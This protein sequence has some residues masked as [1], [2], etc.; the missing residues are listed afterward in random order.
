LVDSTCVWLIQPELDS[1]DMCMTHSTCIWSIQPGLNRPDTYWINPTWVWFFQ[2]MYNW[3]N[4]SWK[5][6]MIHSTWTWWIQHALDQSNLC[7]VDS[8]CVWLI[9][10]ECMTCIWSIQPE[11]DQFDMVNLC[12]FDLTCKWLRGFVMGQKLDW[13]PAGP[14]LFWVHCNSRACHGST[15]AIQVYS[16]HWETPLSESEQCSS[17]RLILRGMFSNTQSF[18]VQRVKQHQS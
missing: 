2:L 1:S 14:A 6:C 11:L 10:P 17:W 4:L 5:V 8:T 7:L 13:W 16:S 3:F 12:L 9:Q 15:M 18:W